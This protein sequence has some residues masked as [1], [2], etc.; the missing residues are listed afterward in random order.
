MFCDVTVCARLSLW[1]CK[2]CIQ[3]ACITSYEHFAQ[4]CLNM[5][6][7]FG[8][9]TN[10]QATIV[11]TFDVKGTGV[12]CVVCGTIEYRINFFFVQNVAN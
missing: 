12:R 11:L 6:E 8:I 7:R 3:L 5:L 4:I 10:T 2:Q 9:M 1:Q